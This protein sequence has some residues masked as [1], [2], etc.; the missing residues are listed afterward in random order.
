M[1]LV[2]GLERPVV[3]AVSGGLAL[4]GSLR[5]GGHRGGAGGSGEGDEGEQ[6][7]GAAPC[8]ATGVVRV[9]SHAAT[10]EASPNGHL[11]AAQRLANGPTH[12]AL[13]PAENQ[14]GLV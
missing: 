13:I 10:V 8:G 3:A 5:S 6:D 12:T 9:G 4:R 2:E 11:S 1:W 7:D 14:P